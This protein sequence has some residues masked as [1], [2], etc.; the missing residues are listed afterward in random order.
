MKD[1]SGNWNF[2]EDFGFGEDKGTVEI[3]QIGDK[4]EGVFEYTEYIEDEKPFT[5]KQPVEGSFDGT[6]FKVEGK[7]VEITTP[8]KSIEYHLD[9][10]EG[11]LNS[12]NQIVGHSHDG[13]GCFGVFVLD[14]KI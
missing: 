14:K 1:L 3:I 12:Q 7:S 6:N 13:K 4:I 5:V 8:E 9:T 10:W 11:I 2:K